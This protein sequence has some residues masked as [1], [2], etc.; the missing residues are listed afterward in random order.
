MRKKNKQFIIGFFLSIL[1][2]QQDTYRSVDD[3]KKEWLEITSYQMEEMLSFSEFLFKKGHYE[4][5]LLTLFELTYKF[6][7]DPIIPN[8]NYHIARCYEEMG[9]YVL[10]QRYYQKVIDLSLI[11]I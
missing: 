5:C 7:D 8:I 10:A 2:S 9:S 11:H 1:V 4:R 6:S 3:I